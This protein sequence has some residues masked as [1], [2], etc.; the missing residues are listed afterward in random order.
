MIKEIKY[1]GISSSPSDYECPD[2]E[3]AA[4]LDAVTEDGSVRPLL[5]PKTLFTLA[6][7]QAVKFIHKTSSYTHYII[8]GAE[9][10]VLWKDAQ[11][12][13]LNTLHTLTDIIG[14]NAIGNTLIA[15]CKEGMHYFLWK[16]DDSSY[17]S[18]G[19]EIPE[20]PIS[21]GLKAESKLYSKQNYGEDN[22][23]GTFTIS[24]DEMS[25]DDIGSTF[26]ESNKQKITEQLLAKI[27]KFINEEGNKKGKFIFPFFVRYAY[28]LYDGN[29]LSHHSAPILMIPST[30]ATPIA[31]WAGNP[32][33]GNGSV[34]K[35]AEIDLIMFPCTLDYQPL[36]TSEEKE[37]LK[38]WSDII[39]SV[40]IFISAPIYTYDQNGECSTIT[41]RFLFRDFGIFV[42]KYNGGDAISAKS[43]TVA[44][45][46][47]YYQEWNNM[48]LLDLI[49]GG[50][51][52]P[53]IFE[54]PRISDTEI[55][56][57]IKDCHTFYHLKSISIDD[58]PTQRTDITI[59]ESYLA[60]LVTKEV[61]TDDYQTHDILIP[62]YS[63]TY[64]SRLNIANVK[65]KLFKGFDTAA[66]VCYTNGLM[67]YSSMLGSDSIEDMTKLESIAVRT[68]LNVDGR[69]VVVKNNPSSMPVRVHLDLYELTFIYR[70]VG[71][72]LYYPDTSAKSMHF[73]DVLNGNFN[74]PL[75]AHT[76]LNGAFYFNG[77]R[78]I[79]KGVALP[80]ISKDTIV[81]LP[82]KLYTSEVN[83]PF[84]FPLSGIKTVGTGRIMGICSAVTALSIGQWGKFPLYAFT[85]EDGVWA[86]E[87]KD[88]GTFS[89]AQP[90]S[91]DICLNTESITQID[92]SVLFASAR[93][94]MTLTGS[95]S[96]CITDTL[97]GQIFQ[98]ADMPG[99]EELV[100][101][102]DIDIQTFSYISFKEY[103]K[104]CQM[105]YDYINQRIIAFNPEKNYAYVY[106]LDSKSWGMMKSQFANKLN[107]YP[108]AY[109]MT[110]D[111][112]LVDV[113]Q[114]EEVKEDEKDGSED[115]NED[116]NEDKTELLIKGVNAV[117]VTRPL[118]L[119]APNNLKSI[120]SIIQRGV[121][122]KGHV[123]QV[124][125]GSRDLI[126]WFPIASSMD[127]YLRGFRASPYKY[128]RMMLICTLEPNETLFGCSVQYDLKYAE[129]LR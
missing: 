105:V 76:G 17:T 10:A 56:Q 95:Q 59:D 61:M 111:N 122:K 119:D 71:Y 22:D 124:L 24:F 123:A 120:A 129:K 72:Y 11:A 45:A 5:P 96:Q 31:F 99:I 80:E 118:K 117:L 23:N 20:C 77:F 9:G 73:N 89:P 29:S 47:T 100:A 44:K 41:S 55:H 38:Q 107:S 26:T 121:F 28:R 113:S 8:Q 27:N 68:K 48:A 101:K 32:Y 64:N 53:Y 37:K 19:S 109:V 1:T 36:I 63:Y 3:L 94:I 18:L 15:L 108:N 74:L 70:A 88:D 85:D 50:I 83:N 25:S 79:E 16:E 78:T 4:M 46:K 30:K 21:F 58:I 54:T 69:S 86:L 51:F 87:V 14:F 115:E 97:D 57:K 67:S 42:G 114:I 6:E 93:G 128:F 98:L 125:Y 102:T 66:M 84:Y 75:E 34:H 82:N 104:S 112:R 49:Y 91:R 106:S 39:K 127:H 35:S 62:E 126:H 81:H 103:V 52:A 65:R 12:E 40:E 33:V 116:E 13:T 7:G 2:G 60:A 43:E 110:T 90:V 92:G